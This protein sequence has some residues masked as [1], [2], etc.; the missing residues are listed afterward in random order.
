MDWERQN[1]TV[2][3]VSKSGRT[4]KRLISY[5]ERFARRTNGARMT[6]TSFS[7]AKVSRGH[8]MKLEAVSKKKDR[9]KPFFL[10]GLNWLVKEQ[11]K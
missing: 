5:P 3:Q 6:V 1:S 11:M 4:Q 8:S 10:E 7:Y 2:N 9:P